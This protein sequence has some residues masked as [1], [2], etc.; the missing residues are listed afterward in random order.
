VVTEARVARVLIADDQT[1][2]R[3]GLAR[4]LEEDPRI[5]LVGQAADGLDAVKKAATLK[6]DVVLMDLRMPGLDGAEATQQI[7]RD[8]PE[9]KVLILSTFETD[10]YVIQ[11]LRAGASGYLLKDAEPAAIASSIMAVLSGER[12]MAG[13]VANRVLDMLTGASTPKEFY[14]GLT[15]REIE[16]LKLMANGQANKQIAYNL[17]ISEKTVRNHISHIYEKLQIYDRAQAVLYAVRKA[18]VEL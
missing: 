8:H 1:L 18:L 16:V 14:D 12:V 5:T 9:V 4:L 10:N 11:A 13:A 17:K 7:V 3:S 15:A 2:F 6:P